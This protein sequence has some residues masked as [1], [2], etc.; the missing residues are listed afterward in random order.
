[1]FYYYSQIIVVT[2][3]AGTCD[4]T[5]TA[6]E[7]CSFP[8]T[9]CTAYSGGGI[10]DCKATHYADGTDCQHSKTRNIGFCFVAYYLLQ[11]N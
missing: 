2:T 8:D 9:E 7:Q 10:C 6:A 1:M 11:F 3:L 4:L 5:D